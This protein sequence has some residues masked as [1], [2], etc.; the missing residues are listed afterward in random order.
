MELVTLK[1]G[2]YYYP[3]D[4]RKKTGIFLEKVLYG[5]VTDDDVEDAVVVLDDAAGGPTYWEATYVFQM[6]NGHPALIFKAVYERG[7]AV[8]L[9]HH[10]LVISAPE[11]MDD[12]PRCC[13]KYM[14]NYILKYCGPQQPV[15]RVVTKSR[16]QLHQAHLDP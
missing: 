11:W 15:F 9:R 2:K 14:V 3:D 8:K 6:K 5:D 10:A 12:D 4:E 7:Q 16:K 13:P 1:N